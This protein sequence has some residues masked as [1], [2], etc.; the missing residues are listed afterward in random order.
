MEELDDKSY[1][2]SSSMQPSEINCDANITHMLPPIRQRLRFV[3]AVLPARARIFVI[4]PFYMVSCD[5]DGFLHSYMCQTHSVHDV[6]T[7][8]L[9]ALTTALAIES[10]ALD[11]GEL[12]GTN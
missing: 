11:E 3:F 4:R 2:D 8:E 5:G 9:Q 12:N 6:A 1:P 10:D 7:D